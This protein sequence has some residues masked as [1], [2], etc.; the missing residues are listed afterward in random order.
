MRKFIL[1]FSILTAASVTTAWYWS[2]SLSDVEEQAA[3]DVP[4]GQMIDAQIDNID[5]LKEQ[6][7][8][9]IAALRK[10]KKK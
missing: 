2:V 7:D 4:G 3:V 8:A 10:G 1:F 9:Y 6:L 5:Q